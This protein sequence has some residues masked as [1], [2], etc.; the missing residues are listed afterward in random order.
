MDIPEKEPL[1]AEHRAYLQKLKR[2]AFRNGIDLVCLSIHQNFVQEDPAE[3]P[4]ADRAHAQ[5][6]RDRLRAGRS[7]HPPQLRPLEHHQETSTT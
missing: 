7:L 5:V 3:P 1:T 6:H 4:E 2:H